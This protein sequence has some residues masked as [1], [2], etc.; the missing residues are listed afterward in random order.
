[1]NSIIRRTDG[2]YI[3]F[4]HLLACSALCIPSFSIF[5][6][7]I[8]CLLPKVESETRATA[9]KNIESKINKI[10]EY[11]TNHSWG[12][13][14]ESARFM[15]AEEAEEEEVSGSEDD[16]EEE[17]EEESETEPDGSPPKKEGSGGR[18]FFLGGSSLG[19]CCYIVRSKEYESEIRSVPSPPLRNRFHNH[20]PDSSKR[21]QYM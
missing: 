11:Y 10:Y 1:M 16:D 15:L 19:T 3:H 13:S 20:R 2:V 5:S 6:R 4:V 8:P 14:N 21:T 9:Q 12:G 17:G 18:V 7:N